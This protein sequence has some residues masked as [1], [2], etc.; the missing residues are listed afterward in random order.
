[1]LHI[2][3]EV[4]FLRHTCLIK[5]DRVEFVAEVEEG[6]ND[7]YFWDGIVGT[8]CCNGSPSEKSDGHGRIYAPSET[9]ALTHLYA[10]RHHGQHP[11]R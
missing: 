11:L 2:D 1:M 6:E 4:F 7:S 3:N 9:S 8:T 10:Q 5:D